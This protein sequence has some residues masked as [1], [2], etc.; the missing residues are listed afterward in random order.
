MR[1]R[2]KGGKIMSKM[3]WGRRSKKVGNPMLVKLPTGK[4][5][6]DSK[7]GGLAFFFVYLK[8]VEGVDRQVCIAGGPSWP[9]QN[10]I[11]G[12]KHIRRLN[13][14]LHRKFSAHKEMASYS[15]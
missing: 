14:E 13:D 15:V 8:K 2:T 1:N 11:I 3:T 9:L 5:W 12:C 7:E 6:K 4:K 10:V